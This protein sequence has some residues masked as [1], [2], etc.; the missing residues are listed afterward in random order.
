M[1]LLSKGSK[2]YTLKS[3]LDFISTDIVGVWL[4]MSF[5]GITSIL[6]E[7]KQFLK[8]P[9]VV[10]FLLFLL[11]MVVYFVFFAFKVYYKKNLIK[12]HQK[13]KRKYAWIVFLIWLLATILSGIFTSKSP[14]LGLEN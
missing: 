12:N 1:F 10:M 4:M 9:K 3:R 5:F 8:S 6:V 11:P 13:L 7:G 14:F 2:K